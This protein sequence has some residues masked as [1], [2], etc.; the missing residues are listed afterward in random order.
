[1]AAKSRQIVAKSVNCRM[2]WQRPPTSHPKE[3]RI[4]AVAVGSNCTLPASCPQRSLGSSGGRRGRRVSR[5]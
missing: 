5:L 2:W 3:P 1:M 4:G